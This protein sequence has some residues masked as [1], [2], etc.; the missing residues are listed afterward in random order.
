V[1]LWHGQPKRG[2]Y[3]RPN[4][5]IFIPASLVWGGTF[6]YIVLSEGAALLSNPPFI[7]LF[8][9]LFALALYMIV[10][11]FWVEAYQRSKTCYGLTNKRVI[12]LG[13]LFSTVK[14]SIPLHFL[15]NVSI[16]EKG[17]GSGTIILGPM[18]TCYRWHISAPPLGNFVYPSFESIDDA[19]FV[20]E[21]IRSAQ[22][23]TT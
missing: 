5:A 16:R 2:L 8:M 10:G 13:G 7:P 20:H 3:L 17:D 19:R 11:R 6:A 21:M 23:Y 22:K 4:D 15:S 12:F 9:W 14:R 1:L 18:T